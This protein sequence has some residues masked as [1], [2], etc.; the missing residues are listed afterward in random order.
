[1]PH[2][3]GIGIGEHARA[4]FGRRGR[5]RRAPQ[6]GVA[7]VLGQRHPLGP[8]RHALEVPAGAEHRMA[9][10]EQVEQLV[11]DQVV[12]H[13]LVVARERGI[14]GN[15]ERAAVGARAAVGVA[16]HGRER[17]PALVRDAGA[18]GIEVQQVDVDG[19]G[20]PEARAAQ[21]IAKAVGQVDAAHGVQVQR[22]VLDHVGH[23]VAVEV[24]AGVER[25]RPV[26]RIED[27]DAVELVALRQRQPVRILRDAAA[28]A[29]GPLLQARLAVGLVLRARRTRQ[30]AQEQGPQHR[31][32]QHGLHATHPCHRGAAP[33][34]AFH[35]RRSISL[36]GPAG[37]SADSIARSSPRP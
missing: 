8:L 6:G 24:D 29:L 11:R 9:V 37:R 33:A 26:E 28:R 18:V 27:A 13:P 22:G 34:R 32:G 35:S 3:V 4:Q 23:A 15:R 30:Q 31:Q 10:L 2:V 16:D 1:M 14:D 5:Q 21:R 17:E 36:A 19:L 20:L 12:L 7:P 25:M